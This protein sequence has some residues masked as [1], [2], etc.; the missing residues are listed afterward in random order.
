[1]SWLESMILHFFPGWAARRAM[2]AHVARQF[3]G[4]D[5]GRLRTKKN[6]PSYGPKAENR[7]TRATL[8]AVARELDRNNS[9][10]HG[11]FNSL[12]NN[13]VGRGFGLEARTQ[14]RDGKLFEPANR[15]IE[16][17]WKAW[18]AKADS[19]GR[20]T[21]GQIQQLVE[22]E[23]WVAG[24]VLVVRTVARDDGR[25]VPLG[26]EVVESERL[27]A[28]DGTGKGSNTIVQ[29]VEFNSRGE[30]E[31]YHIYADFPG[32]SV[33]TPELNRIE[34]VRVLHLFHQYRPGQARGHS[35]IA[36][37]ARNFEALGQYLDHELTRARIAASFAMMIKRGG[38]SMAPK[39]PLPASG[40]PTTDDNGNVLGQIEGGMMF[41]GGP[42][43]SIE[44]TG[45]SVQTT[46]FEQF[47]TVNL[48]AI[49]IGL[50]MSYELLSRDFTKATFSS[51]RQATQE[52]I[53]HWSPRQVFLNEHLNDP[54]FVWFVDSAILAGV[55]PF[56]SNERRID[57]EWIMPGRDYIDPKV[58]AEADILL[59][60]S[61]F[62]NAQKVAAKHGTDIHENLKL[63][64]RIKEAAEAQGLLLA[65]FM[66]QEEIEQKERVETQKAEAQAEAAKAAATKPT[67]V[68]PEEDQEDSDVA[69]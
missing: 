66:E 24:E 44:G 3:T 7:Q 37:V 18:A 61:G 28:I 48:R 26:L 59:I 6:Y 41:Y 51:A 2:N 35:R 36:S 11:A 52:D 56:S 5:L 29:G 16:E 63:N 39:F 54:V 50:N 33:A 46:A 27:A 22:R 25:T 45:P 15:L 9:F 20:L 10:A 23:L 14:S 60:Q 62:T 67:L 47:I 1:M 12:V 17:E 40:D 42:N 4:A 31:A 55:Q 43:D 58:E 69:A 64:A 38:L 19:R 49:A 21:Y 34:A 8:L 57:W 30:V 13:I 32:D 65:P 68:K 53:R